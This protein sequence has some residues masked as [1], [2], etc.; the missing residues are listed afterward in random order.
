MIK[1]NM[2]MNNQIVAN[3]FKPDLLFADST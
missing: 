3:H 1:Y 2:Q